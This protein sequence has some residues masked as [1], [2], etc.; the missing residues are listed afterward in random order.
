MG[1]A[2]MSEWFDYRTLSAVGDGNPISSWAGKRGL[3]T[4]TASGSARP[5]FATDDGD[6]RSS[7]QFDGVDDV[8]S[9]LI[10][11]FDLYGS[12]GDFEIWVVVRGSSSSLPKAGIW[13]GGGETQNVVIDAGVSPPT[14]F[15]QTPGDS[16]FPISGAANVCDDAWHVVRVVRMGTHRLIWVDGMLISTFTDISG[17][18]SAGQDV[19]LIGN[20]PNAHYWLGGIRHALAFKAPLNETTAAHLTS[21]LLTA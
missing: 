13:W 2:A 16:T 17:T 4:L 1:I 19:I 20:D 10:S 12:T 18:W 14:M 15:F 8:L 9:T 7:A 11:N 5:T 6:G 3:Y 21:Y